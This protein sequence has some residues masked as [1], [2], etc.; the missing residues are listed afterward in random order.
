V[1]TRAQRRKKWLHLARPVV[2]AREAKQREKARQR[3]QHRAVQRVLVGR[4]TR[5]TRE[6]GR[7][8]GEGGKGGEEEV[9]WKE[10]MKLTTAL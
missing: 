4:Q 3:T 8:R 7:Q 9:D 6:V 1:V 2:V 5:A 10:L